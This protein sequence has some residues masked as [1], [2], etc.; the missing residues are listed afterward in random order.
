MTQSQE[1]LTEK[2]FK[3][4]DDDLNMGLKKPI[5]IIGLHRSGSTMWANII[6]KNPKILRIGEIYFIAPLKNDFKYF[7]SKF[8]GDLS[9]DKNIEKMINL[10]FQNNGGVK[11]AGSFCSTLV[12]RVNSP[13]LKERLYKRI[14]ESDRSLEAIFCALIEE[15]TIFKGFR[16]CCV[17]FPVEFNQISELLKWYPECKIIHITRDPRATCVSRINYP[18]GRHKKIIKQYPASGPITRKLHLIYVSMEYILTSF[19][20]LQYASHQNYKL[21]RYEDL[22]VNPQKT[23]KELCGFADLEYHP[24]MLVPGE[25][26][27][28][29]ITGKASRLIDIKN[30][31]HWKSKITPIENLMILLLTKSSMGRLGYNPQKHPIAKYQ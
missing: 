18:G 26:Q 12:R 30:N 14:Y 15:I 5:F 20:H 27:P 19:I 4:P 9:E 8:I 24:N 10:I 22:L 2:K 7:C 25:G 23:I 31:F 1:I 17:K 21:F 13:Y 3:M 6:A 29:S 11:L 16:R 28:S